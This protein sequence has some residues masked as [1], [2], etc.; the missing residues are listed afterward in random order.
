MRNKNSI[1][2][3]TAKIKIKRTE[4]RKK[5]AGDLLSACKPYKCHSIKIIFIENLNLLFGFNNLMLHASDFLTLFYIC[6]NK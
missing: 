1:F 2:L 4:G 5:D 3:K 6:G